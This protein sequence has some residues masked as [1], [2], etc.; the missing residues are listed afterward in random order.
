MICL[1]GNQTLF[2]RLRATWPKGYQCG[3]QRKSSQNGDYL[4]RSSA[5]KF[6]FLQELNLQPLDYQCT[7]IPLELPKTSL[8]VLNC[9][10]VFCSLLNL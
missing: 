8:R 4:K 6:A 7:A 5:K 3:S 2:N 10:D 9:G 1:A